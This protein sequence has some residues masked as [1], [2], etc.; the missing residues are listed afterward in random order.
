MPRYFMHLMGPITYNY[1]SPFVFD[2][3]A[4]ALEL[5]EFNLFED[6]NPNE[7]MI[8]IYRMPTENGAGELVW[9]FM[10]VNFCDALLFDEESTPDYIPPL[11][12]GKL[13]DHATSL[14]EELVDAHTPDWLDNADDENDINEIISAITAD[15]K[16]RAAAAGGFV[17]LADGYD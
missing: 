13:N 12:Q 4:E 5:I 16:N 15:S 1:P 10:G 14:L 3:L 6:L 17:S 2:F 8:C 7:D 11:R 9:R